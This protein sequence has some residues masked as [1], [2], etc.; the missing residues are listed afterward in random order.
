MVP[1]V[2]TVEGLTSQH[3]KRWG[4]NVNK[5]GWVNWPDAQQRIYKNNGTIRWT[6]K[7]HERLEG[8]KTVTTLPI[9]EKWALQHP[10]DIKRQ[11]KQNNYYDTL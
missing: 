6:G 1:R 3:I 8:Y 9:N 2:N 4:W 7:V 11:E 10:K 5:K